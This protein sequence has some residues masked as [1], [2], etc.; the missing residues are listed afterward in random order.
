MPT[1]LNII[2]KISERCIEEI[3]VVDWTCIKILQRK[4]RCHLNTVIG[5]LKII[6]KHDAS[7]RSATFSFI[8][9]RKMNISQDFLRKL[10]LILNKSIIF[11]T[12]I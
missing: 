6:S 2:T 3:S 4:T 10:L 11:G 1:N 7:V 9:R 5:F 8:K 12:W